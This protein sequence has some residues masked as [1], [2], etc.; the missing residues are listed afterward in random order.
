M[1]KK[2]SWKCLTALALSVAMLVPVQAAF[3]AEEQ[4]T[5]S[6]TEAYEESS[7]ADADGFKIENGVLKKYTG[8]ASEVVVPEGVTSIGEY[9]FADN[10]NLLSVSIPQSVVSIG[11]S[12][13]AGC[14]KL[15]GIYIPAHVADIG[16][17]AFIDCCLK[18]I[19]VENGN[20]VY[21]SRENCN[22]II[23]T[24]TNTLLF[25]CPNTIIPEGTKHIAHCAFFRTGIATVN[26]PKG[27]MSI[28]DSAFFACNMTEVIFPEELTSIGKAAFSQSKELAK[29]SVPEKVTHIGLSAFELCGNLSTI[30]V[31]EGNTVYDSRENCNA[32]IETE[33]NTLILGCQNTIIPEGVTGIGERAFMGSGYLKKIDIPETVTHIESYAFWMC[34]NLKEVN[35]PESV[36]T[37]GEM[38]FKGDV[39]GVTIYGKTGSYA[40]IYAEQ[41]NIN[42]S[43]HPL[44]TISSNDV[45]LSQ[46]TYTYDGTAKTPIVTVKDETAILKEGK[47]YTLTYRNNSNAGTATV[48]VTGTGNYKGTVTKNFI[49]AV[50]KGTSHKAGFYQYQVTGTSTVS[51]TGVTN[52]KI[53]KIK[54]PKTVKIGGKTF[55]VAAIGNNAFQNNKKI[56][57]IEIG[58]N[59]K[60][61]GVSALEGCTKLSKATIGKG[62]A[63]IRGNAFKNCK[64]L[65]TVDIKSMKLKKVGRNALTG[66]KPTSKIKVPA[67]KLSAYKKLFKNKGQSRKVKIVK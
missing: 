32:V 12:A 54:I 23:E 45:S 41:H 46:T 7:T 61:I 39:D 28:G 16:E 25:G 37:I 5:E 11:E 47:D 24:E 51:V 8:T 18:T 22:A 6:G 17:H 57:S 38:A 21:D 52:H 29:I 26:F 67:K 10:I 3:A 20:T 58:S 62:V 1:R 19:I 40:E 53:T 27:V 50:K 34:R 36:K 30:E 60:T 66:I 33:S 43:L 64:K 48:I 2:K 4:T 31:A 49:I 13:F 65:G 56:T 15:T 14:S 35:I 63:E 9:A 55:K 59:V 42:F 44:K